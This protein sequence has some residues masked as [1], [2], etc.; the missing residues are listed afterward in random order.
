MP[1]YRREYASSTRPQS[2]PT[3][4]WLSVSTASYSEYRQP[5]LPPMIC[6]LARWEHSRAESPDLTCGFNPW[7]QDI[8]APARYLIDP[9]G[10]SLIRSSR[11]IGAR[12]FHT[13]RE[14][15]FFNRIGRLRK[16]GEYA[17]GHPIRRSATDPCD[18]PP[19]AGR[20]QVSFW[21]RRPWNQ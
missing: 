19:H 14:I 10:P 1:G 12:I 18:A 7:T 13:S 6:A 15:E 17:S 4:N 21:T 8:G 5:P 2:K 20:W 16:Y 11:P 3:S 9:V